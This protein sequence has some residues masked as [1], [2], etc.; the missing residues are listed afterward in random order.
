MYESTAGLHGLIMK[1]TAAVQVGPVSAKTHTA[2]PCRQL[3]IS[4]CYCAQQTLLVA[5][6]ASGTR[7]RE[8]THKDTFRQR[9]I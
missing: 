7:K 6:A 4:S 8:L 9:P 5:S 3:A 1:E 2:Q